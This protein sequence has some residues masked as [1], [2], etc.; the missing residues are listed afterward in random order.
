[1][2]DDFNAI[3]GTSPQASNAAQPGTTVL[4]PKSFANVWLTA[5]PPKETVEDTDNITSAINAAT[6]GFSTAFRL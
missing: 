5:E 1:M 6:G 3:W 4:D 2:A